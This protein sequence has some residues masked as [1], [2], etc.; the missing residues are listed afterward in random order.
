[1]LPGKGNLLQSGL[2]LAITALGNR[3]TAKSW[4]DG[5]IQ[6]KRSHAIAIDAC[7]CFVF[8]FATQEWCFEDCQRRTKSLQ[9]PH[10]IFT[11]R[12][13]AAASWKEIESSACGTEEA[14]TKDERLSVLIE[15]G[16]STQHSSHSKAVCCL[17]LRWLP[18]F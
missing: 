9:P 11:L 17:P 10:T 4:E 2:I 18:E 12:T 13:G 3:A 6:D 1:M 14:S 15:P 16:N 8:V 5:S 7:S